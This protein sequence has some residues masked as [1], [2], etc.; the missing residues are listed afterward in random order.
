L[1]F[2]L[3]LAK[4]FGRSE[5]GASAAGKAALDSSALAEERMQA[6]HEAMNT[7]QGAFDRRDYAA[8]ADA[9]LKALEIRHDD[10]A[11]HFGLGLVY[12]KQQRDED[13]VDSFTMALHFRPEYAEPFYNLA[14]I[15]RKRGELPVAIEYLNQA[16]RLHPRHAEAHNLLGACLLSHGHPERAAESFERAVNI[17][18]LRAHYRSNLGYVLLRDL[19]CVEQGASHIIAALEM[20]RNDPAIWCNYCAVLSNEG[21]LGEV[22]SICDQLLAA[23]P[24]LHEARLNRA[25]ANLKMGRFDD[26][27]PDYAARKLTRSNYRQRAYGFHEWR[28]EPLA[29]KTILIFAEQGIGDEIMFASCIPDI[30]K[31]G[32]RCIVDCSP[33][34]AGVFSRSFPDAVVH[35]T[36]QADVDTSW[37]Q[38]HARVDYQVAAGDL[39]GFFRRRREDFPEH[40][41]YLRA[42]PARATHWRAKLNSGGD[43]RNIG[44]AWRGGMRSTR[45]GVRSMELGEL[46]PVLRTPGNRFVSL[47][48]DATPAELAAGA[49][50]HGAALENWPDVLADFDET[51]ALMMALDLVI[52]VCSAPVHLSGALGRPAWVLVPSIAEWRYMESGERMPWYPDVRMFRQKKS[53]DWQEVIQSIAVALA[54]PGARSC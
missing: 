54:E 50:G 18:P 16:L 41:A 5:S 14:L 20:D 13:A 48:H 37:L 51:A 30:L 45:Q 29:G 52:T 38:S 10:A 35:G 40:G 8:A 6:A 47:Q 31:S 11:A 49:I 9:Y 24:E 23:N 22:V 1:S 25:L 19:G 17:D 2:L 21:K 28:G 36:S 34:L 46:L 27:W 33:R 3:K 53:G 15:A 42:D 7:A 32:A 26:A 43:L 4:L 39:P 12:L 44:I